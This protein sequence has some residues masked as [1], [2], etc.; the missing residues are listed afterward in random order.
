MNIHSRLF[1]RVA[2]KRR[3]FWLAIVLIPVLLAGLGMPQSAGNLAA[4]AQELASATPSLQPSIPVAGEISPP[5]VKPDTYHWPTFDEAL[6]TTGATPPPGTYRGKTVTG[7]ANQLLNVPPFVWHNGCG[8]TAAGMVLAYWNER[9]FKKLFPG[10]A[11]SQSDEVNQVI[12]SDEHYND[13]SLPLDDIEHSDKIL[14]D[15]SEDPQ[16]DE[17]LDNSVADFMKT[18]QSVHGLRYGWSSSRFMPVGFEGYIQSVAP[19]YSYI[20]RFLTMEDGFSWERYKGEIDASRPVMLVVDTDGDGETDHAG[21]GIGYDDSDGQMIAVYDTWD[22]EVHWYPFAKMD[23]G[24][25]WGI[26]G[27]VMLN[28]GL[29]FQANT[30]EDAPDVNPGDGICMTADGKCSL[31]AAVQESNAILSYDTILLPPGT[32][33]LTIPGQNEDAAASGDLDITDSVLISGAGKTATII[34]GS[35]LDSV[36]SI[37]E[38]AGASVAQGKASAAQAPGMFL[39]FFNSVTIRNGVG[40]INAWGS[41]DLWVENSQVIDNSASGVWTTGANVALTRSTVGNNQSSANAGGVQINA[42]YL[43]VIASSI[44]GNSGTVGGISADSGLLM[45]EST[46][47]TNTGTAGA[48]GVSL[49]GVGAIVNSTISSNT[50]SE[51]GGLSTDTDLVLLNSTV[52]KNTTSAN[53]GGVLAKTANKVILTNSLLSDNVSGFS[54]D[55]SGSFNSGGYNLIGNAGGCTIATVQ[56]DLLGANAFLGA[57]ADNDGP[58]YTHALSLGSAAI[59][60]AN[61]LGCTDQKAASLLHDQRFMPRPVDG[62]GDGVAVCD[63]GAFEAQ[64]IPLTPVA[65]V[66]PLPPVT[67]LPTTTQVLTQTPLP[68][69]STPQATSTGQPGTQTAV[70]SATTAPSSTPTSAVTPTASR[71]PTSTSTVSACY[72]AIVNGGFETDEAWYL[73]ATRYT[74]GYDIIYLQEATA[75][76][77]TEEVHSGG[78]SMRTGIL[79]PLKNVYSYSSAWQQVSIPANAT[80]ANLSFWLFQRSVDGIDGYDVQL[81]LL[82]D[83]NKREFERPVNVRSDSR[84]WTQ[85]QFD[86]KKYAGKTVWVYFGTY[87]NGWNSTMAMYTDDVSLMICKP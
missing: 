68:A 9:G 48:G 43:T 25:Q 86:L 78:R 21:V 44:Q 30:T 19:E 74:A 7:A 51:G 38:G 71:T 23:I 46:V 4:R 56:G 36:F 45:T 63:I 17:H 8:P 49:T 28:M 62:N 83:S 70:P 60:A 3:R 55:C 40:G 47:H 80:S 77:S 59:D 12:A 54:P 81:M 76:Y 53:G 61:P 31:R 50:G 29:I 22:T 15:K 32:Y 10:S 34:D 67:L 69:S 33:T 75:N 41:G 42:G 82:L 11:S 52:A 37:G 87:N 84:T 27:G 39:V 72:E 13:Y 16:G 5:A 2:H 14:P 26:Y 79:D 35:G 58:T 24:Q 85:Y 73:P 1:L 65:S 66:T 6:T 57:L 18:S 64:G 20:Q